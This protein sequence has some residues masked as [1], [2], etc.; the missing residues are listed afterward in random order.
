MYN[1][2]LSVDPYHEGALVGLSSV[3]QYMNESEEAL[4][5]EKK[6]I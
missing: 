1:K 5:V 6:H 4:R 3:Y 2:V